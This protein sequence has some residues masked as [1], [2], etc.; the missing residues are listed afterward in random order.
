MEILLSGIVGSTAYGLAGPQ[1]DVDRLGVFA[2]PTVALHGLHPP[3]ESVVT[4]RP[5]RTLHEAA[6]WCRLALSSNPTAAELVWL[7]EQLYEVRTELGDQLIAIRSA[8]PSAKRVRDAYLGYASQQFHRLAARGDGSFGSDLRNRT[9][10]HARHLAR[11][12][13]QGLELYTTGEVHVRLADPQWFLDFGER[14]AGG[15]LDAARSLLD[16]AGQKF[17]TVRTPLPDKPDE[18]SVEAWL[19][20]VRAAHLDTE[21]RRH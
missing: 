6:K 11:L 5:D 14:V 9:A 1:S 13:H 7:P 3:A 19:L 10:K 20:R 15:D 4:T 18:A 8:F 12:V 2:A 17:D 21:W 16:D